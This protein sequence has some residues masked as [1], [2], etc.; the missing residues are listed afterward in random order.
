MPKKTTAALPKKPA[1]N[2]PA[3]DKKLSALDAA[4]KVLGDSTEPMATKEMIDAMSA[5]GYWTSP[6]GQTPHA[7]LYAAI[8]REISTKGA[9]ARFVKTDRGRFGLST[10]AE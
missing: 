3:S 7:T 10:A 9:D 2:K 5:R 8:L 4:A 1:K 6:G